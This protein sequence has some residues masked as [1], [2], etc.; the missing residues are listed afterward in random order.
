[1]VERKFSSATKHLW[2]LLLYWLIKAQEYYAAKDSKTALWPIAELR[3]LK[4]GQS[5]LALHGTLRSNLRSY[6]LGLDFAE[7]HL[8]RIWWCCASE[9]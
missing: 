2:Q 7:F 5:S 4:S 8:G 6:V 9:G 1:M 3:I